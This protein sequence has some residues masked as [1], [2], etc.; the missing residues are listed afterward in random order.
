M[1]R[2]SREIRTEDSIIFI[3]IIY[4][5]SYSYGGHYLRYIKNGVSNM[6]RRVLNRAGNPPLFHS[7]KSRRLQSIHGKA[8]R[9][10][11]CILATYELPRL[12]NG[13][14]YI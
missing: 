3:R 9:F 7:Y 5:K 6:H 1:I 10:D 2:L 12:I 13:D 14:H 11:P 4:V 8:S